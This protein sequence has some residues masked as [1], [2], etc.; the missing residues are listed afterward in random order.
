MKASPKPKV[1]FFLSC[2]AKLVSVHVHFPEGAVA[3]I[4]FYTVEAEVVLELHEFP[5]TCPCGR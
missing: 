1:G 5:N 3:S 2:L 4:L